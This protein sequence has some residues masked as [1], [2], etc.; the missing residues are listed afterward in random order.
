MFFFG[1][2]R[3]KYLLK[4]SNR[5]VW[6]GSNNFNWRKQGN[7]GVCNGKKKQNEKQSN[8]EKPQNRKFENAAEKKI[9]LWLILWKSKQNRGNIR[10]NFIGKAEQN[11]NVL[12]DQ[13]LIKL[14]KGFHSWL[15]IYTF[16][17]CYWRRWLSKVCFDILHDT[18]KRGFIKD[19][20]Q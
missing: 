16:L 10:K 4:T 11:T 5:W 14:R 6:T 8:N 20:P 9:E 7:F 12:I 18:F 1:G 19:N 2:E 15:D 3:R 17:Q 13:N